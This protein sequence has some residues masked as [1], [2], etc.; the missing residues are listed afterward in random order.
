MKSDQGLV[1][2]RIT[3]DTTNNTDDS[4]ERLELNGLVEVDITRAAE[5]INIDF[6]ITGTG[7]LTSIT[8]NA[9]EVY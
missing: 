5:N 8:D 6:V 4:I 7:E 3:V 1:D 9:G 2:Y